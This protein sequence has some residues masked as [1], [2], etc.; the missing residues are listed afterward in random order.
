MYLDIKCAFQNGKLTDLVYVGPPEELGDG[1]G[2]VWR[3]RKALYGLKQAAREWHKVLVELLCDLDFVRCHNDPALHVRKYGRCIIFIWVDDLLIFTTPYVMKPLCDQILAT[4][5]GCSEGKI[6]EIGKVLGMEIMRDRP[7]QT[8]TISHRMK[9]KDL[10]DSN[11]MKG[12]CTSP[13]PLVPKEKLK[14]LKED[15]S[16]EPATAS[17]HQPYI[18]VAGSIQY[19]ACVTRPDLAFAAHSLARHMSACYEIPSKDC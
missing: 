2:N 4:F 19:I 9:L 10:L 6:G 11:G 7:S 18:K 1:S 3:A 5:K 13:T 15:P 16:Q 8:M 12:C 14:S 17:E